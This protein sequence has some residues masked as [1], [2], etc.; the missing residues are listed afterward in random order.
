MVQAAT[1][2]GVGLQVKDPVAARDRALEHLRVEHVALD[3]PHP[4][5][6]ECFRDELPPAGAEVVDDHDLHA[7]GIEPVDEVAADESGA[8]RDAGAPHGAGSFRPAGR[9]ALAGRTGIYSVKPAAAAS[10]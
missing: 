7:V 1:H 2:V 8:A 5:A 9:V 6:L 10:P 3:E 4:G